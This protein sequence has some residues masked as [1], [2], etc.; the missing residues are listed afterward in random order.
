MVN[1]QYEY[2]LGKNINEVELSGI[3]PQ[4]DNLISNKYLYLFDI[5]VKYHNNDI[6]TIFITTDE[7]DKINQ[8]KINLL[9]LINESFFN[10]LVDQYGKPDNILIIDKV[11]SNS[12]ENLNP[13]SSYEQYVQKR[14]FKTREGNFQE[15]PIYIIWNK[16]DFQITFLMKYKQNTT[17]ITFKKKY[18]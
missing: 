11:I 18:V 17:E 3:K 15:K 1:N 9:A 8:L 2:L 14:A 7:N 6:Y 12:G 5:P 16:D 4:K 13:K 10:V